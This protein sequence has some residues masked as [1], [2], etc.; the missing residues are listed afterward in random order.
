M[1]HNPRTAYRPDI[2]N[3]GTGSGNNYAYLISDELTKDAMVIDPAHPP[4]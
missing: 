3:T 2:D 1:H 4:E